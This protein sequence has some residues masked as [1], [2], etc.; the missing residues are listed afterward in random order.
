[1][2]N[3]AT[4][5]HHDMAVIATI[6]P[7][8]LTDDRFEKLIG[9]QAWQQLPILVRNR[10]SKTLAN[11]RIVYYRGKN[12]QLKRNIFGTILAQVLRIVG[13]PLP[14]FKE[15]NL[16]SIVTVYE[17]KNSG[18]QVWSRQYQRENK[19]PQVIES[20]KKFSGETGLEEYIGFGLSIALQAKVSKNT[21]AFHGHSF[22]FKFGKIQFKLP[23]WLE[24]GKLLV[25]H[26][27]LGSGDFEFTLS[28]YHNIF[29]ELLYQSAIYHDSPQLAEG[30]A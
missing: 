16:P 4:K 9:Q 26:H 22:H 29:G 11:N 1:M 7:Q 21:L 5:N 3:L 8:Q 25:K 10:F 14:I 2:L 13:A 30:N 15:V 23:K 20:V 28:L 17:D 27:D 24:P 12:T 19:P 6:K 18:G